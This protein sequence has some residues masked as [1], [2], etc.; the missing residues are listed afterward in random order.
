MTVQYIT[1]H[2]HS[3]TVKGDYKTK[4]GFFV[5]TNYKDNKIK[6]PCPKPVDIMKKLIINLSEE[7]DIV[8]D[9]F[10]G[11]GA[12]ALACKQLKRNF[13]GIELNEDY[14]KLANGRLEQSSL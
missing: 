11:S 1:V 5:S 14:I 3:I 8:L 6:H 9:C 13:I 12:T 7:G 4:R 10:M 2:I